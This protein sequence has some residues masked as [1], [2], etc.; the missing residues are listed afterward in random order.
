VRSLGELLEDLLRY[1][2]RTAQYLLDEDFL[3]ARMR[4][5]KIEEKE[6]ELRE[7][8]E[9]LKKRERKVE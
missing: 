5:Q 4:S 1:C 7:R 9:K 3:R 2:H 6:E 8:E